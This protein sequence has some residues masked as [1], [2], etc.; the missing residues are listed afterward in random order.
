MMESD[1]QI[2]PS[3]TPP[4]R[5]H[6]TQTRKDWKHT[7][8]SV[9]ANLPD[10]EASLPLRRAGSCFLFIFEQVEVYVYSGQ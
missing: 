1:L 9:E 2:Y 6:H 10:F 4:R 8:R 3:T 7:C 5:H